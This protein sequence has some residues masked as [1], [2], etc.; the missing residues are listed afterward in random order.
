MTPKQ[1]TRMAQIAK[2]IASPYRMIVFTRF[3]D[4]EALVQGQEYLGS[5][6][7]VPLPQGEKCLR[8]LC[9]L[10]LV[11]SER[12]KGEHRSLGY[13][14]TPMG[15]QLQATIKEVMTECLAP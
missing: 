7:D 15:R 14:L 10:Q 3:P 8:E 2:A 9:R 5:I 1:L 12:I 11:Y 13:R 6:L 4:Q